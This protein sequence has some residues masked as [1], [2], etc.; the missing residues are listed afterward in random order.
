MKRRLLIG[1]TI[2][3]VVG[4]SFFS[5]TRDQKNFEI[6]KNLDIY[7]TLFRELNMFYVDDVNPNDLVKTSI[8]KMLESL[9]PYTNYISE[10]QIEDFRFMTTGEYAGIGALISKQNDKIII[11]EPYEGFP[12]QKFGLKA[13]DILLEVEGK[14]TSEMSTEDVSSLLKGPANKPVSIKVQRPGQKKTFTVD[15]VREKISINAVPYYGM[16]D[17]STAYIRLSNFTANCSAD[18]QKAFLEL[19]ENNPDGLILDLRGNPGGLLMEAVK[20]VNFFVP[21]GE[22]IVSTKGKVKQWDK[23]YKANA[24]P[25]DTTIKIAVLVNSGSASASEIVAGAIQDLDR[26]IVVGTRTF[27]KGLVQTTRD[28]SYN[29]KLKVTTAKYYIPSGRC[30]QALDYSHRNDD[31][32]VGHIPDSLITEFT[33][34]KGRKVYDGGGV[35]PDVKIEGEQLSTLAIELVTRFMIFDFATRYSNENESIPEPE[36]FSITDDIYKQ[37]ATFVQQS[38]FKYESASQDDLEALLKTAKREKY[39]GLAEAE[40]EALKAKLEPDLEKDL[41][42]FREELSELLESEIVSRYYYQKGSIRA[43]IN[44]DKGIKKTIEAMHSE[45]AYAGY[46]QPGLVVGMN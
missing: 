32:S 26:G 37:F 17:Q 15:V 22:E 18:V 34:K 8:D 31:G 12:A 39:Y 3:A 14:N 36:A 43:S 33:T 19:K 40:F 20:I 2:V 10:D 29:T 24:A 45:T 4:I 6:A 38:E 30:I 28:L 42:V 11:A 35:V 41:G 46:F 9:D 7:H 27:G 25:M 21:Q 44:D 16:I 1:I 5:F 13:G 23:V